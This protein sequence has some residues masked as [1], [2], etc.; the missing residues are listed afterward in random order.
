MGEW[1][2]SPHLTAAACRYAEAA[3]KAEIAVFVEMCLPRL[4]DTARTHGYA[5]AVHG[6]LA[7]D[8]DLVA[9]PWTDRADDADTLRS[10][11]CATT[12]DATGWG[13]ISDSGKWSEKPHG[14][15]ATTIIASSDVHLDL[16]VMPRVPKAEPP[17]RPSSPD[18]L[19][20]QAR[21]LSPSSCL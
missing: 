19:L 7:R 8:L 3:R 15:V 11:L 4:I 9:I 2:H 21:F 1:H 6:S 10:A 20:E 18:A 5:L 12:K 13:Y 14:R 17:E 16:S